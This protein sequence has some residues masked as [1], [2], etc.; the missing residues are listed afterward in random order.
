MC[1]FLRDGVTRLVQIKSAFNLLSWIQNRHHATTQHHGYDPDMN[2]APLAAFDT[3]TSLKCPIE[4]SVAARVWLTVQ[5]IAWPFTA[6]MALL[7]WLWVV[8]PLF[9]IKRGHWVDI[10]A[11]AVQHM[12]FFYMSPAGCTFA[13]SCGM[14]AVAAWWTGFFLFIN[15][16]ISHSPVSFAVRNPV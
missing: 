7:H 14:H 5:H 2:G 3:R 6:G 13:N 12:I 16:A 10:G 8:H 4:Q 11:I 15:F 9:A 1:T